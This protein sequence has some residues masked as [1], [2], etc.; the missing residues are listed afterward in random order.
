MTTEAV[1]R[2]F[3]ENAK[4]WIED[5]YGQNPW[6]YPFGLHR[7]RITLDVW[8]RHYPCASG[9]R[10]VDLAC[11]GGRLAIEEARRGHEVW[12]V[13]QSDAMLSA[14]RQAV[15]ALP[16]STRRRLKFIVSD[17]FEADLPLESFD[18]AT[19]LG[20][21]EY[22][23]DEEAFL[24]KVVRW[25][26]PGALLV[27]DCRNRLFNLYS[28]SSYTKKE[29][30]DRN[31]Q[32][33][34][35]IQELYQPLSEDESRLFLSELTRIAADLARDLRSMPR[36]PSDSERYA[37][38]AEGKQQT[39]REMAELAGRCGFEAVSFHGVHPHLGP[40]KLNELLPMPVYNRLS[41][42]L[43]PFENHPMS[44]LWSSK[45]IVVLRRTR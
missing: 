36:P 45:F 30:Q 14:A 20:L 34:H 21:L 6:V 26:K 7:M 19:A 5:A 29:L 44:L 27:L 28:I 22:L 13:D 40:P 33:A 31:V 42:S 8:E 2:Y 38:V 11:G 23:P 16:E 35:E 10:L 25:L 41:D 4:V 43:L 39:P 17:V 9:L 24:G 1:C 18:G 12:G 32:L 3:E 37:G 15:D